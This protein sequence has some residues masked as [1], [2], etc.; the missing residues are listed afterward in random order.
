MKG[1]VKKILGVFLI[2]IIIILIGMVDASAAKVVRLS[3]NKVVMEVDSY[4][5]LKVL[6]GN[7]KTKWA[8]SDK[9]I[10]KVSNKGKVTAVAEGTTN[11]TATVGKTTLSCSVT[12]VDSNKVKKNSEKTTEF[13]AEKVIKKLKI[14]REYK[15][16]DRE[17]YICV[18]NT[19]T[20][21]IDLGIDIRFYD[22]DNSLVSY[23]NAYK[24]AIGPKG[25]VCFKFYTE[26]AYDHYDI[27]W[28][29][30]KPLFHVLD[31]RDMKL[32]ITQRDDR[33]IIEA[34]NIGDVRAVSVEYYV[35]FLKK[36][37]V[38]SDESGYFIG[39]SSEIKPGQSGLDTIWIDTSLYDSIK[40]F[41]TGYE[42]N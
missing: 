40:V 1:A 29:V 12:V 22:V 34:T 42:E 28:N 2:L 4:L 25:E 31:C 39:N 8:S 6:D 13:D 9:N 17:A 10:A 27:Q 19:S 24:H 41:M 11:I 14:T 30:T 33:V 35:L 38:V 37:K 16:S 21:S 36:G 7:G 20:F 23:S 32:S 5:N 18:K 26:E 3:K 15:G